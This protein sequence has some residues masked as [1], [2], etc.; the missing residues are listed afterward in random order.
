MFE[1]SAA[2]IAALG[3]EDL[4][5]LIARLYEAEMRALQLA[6]VRMRSAPPPFHG[7]CSG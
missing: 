1:I 6:A 2:D 3:D 7:L 5:T 4:R